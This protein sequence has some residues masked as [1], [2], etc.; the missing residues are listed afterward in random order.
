MSDVLGLLES[1][2]PRRVR[3]CDV[4]V[5]KLN[6]PKKR[7]QNEESNANKKFKFGEDE[8]YVNWF[9]SPRKQ[10]HSLQCQVCN[11]NFKDGTALRY[12]QI[13]HPPPVNPSL[14]E[15]GIPDE[16]ASRL[17]GEGLIISPAN[18]GGP[19][20]VKRVRVKSSLD[21]SIPRIRDSS[22]NNELTATKPNTDATSL[23]RTNSSPHALKRNPRIR[24]SKLSHAASWKVEDKTTVSS[25]R[26]ATQGGDNGEVS[27]NKTELLSEVETGDTGLNDSTAS[28]PNVSLDSCASGSSL[29]ADKLEPDVVTYGAGKRP[30]WN[31]FG[32]VRTPT[33][34]WRKQRKRF[35]RSQGKL[36]AP[37]SSTT[38]GG[39]SA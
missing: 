16:T 19:S 24:I 34:V 36:P 28:S 23:T 18:K 37:A 6:L 20:N 8:Y 1:G 27:N 14:S 22:K 17:S 31:L 12:H 39:I 11:K 13:Y 3:H 4:K 29:E 25:S 32:T 33:A 7:K 9:I 35:N 26:G 21:N 30:R 5:V 10:S 38:T 15:L 2:K